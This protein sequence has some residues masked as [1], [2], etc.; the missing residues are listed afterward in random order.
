MTSPLA[1]GHSFVE[2]WET[3]R[4]HEYSLNLDMH[5]THEVST[6]LKTNKPITPKAY[7]LGL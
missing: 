6:R 7:E 5:I 2:E 4:V 1:V 3:N